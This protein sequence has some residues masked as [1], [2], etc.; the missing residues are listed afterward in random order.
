MLR[1]RFRSE[2]VKS[3]YVPI[4]LFLLIVAFL[5]MK[6]LQDGSKYVNPF[7]SGKLDE[8]AGKENKTSSVS[9]GKIND[10]AVDYNSSSQSNQTNTSSTVG[11]NENNTETSK[12]TV[13]LTEAYN[14]LLARIDPLREELNAKKKNI[15]A[16]IEDLEAAISLNKTIDGDFLKSKLRENNLTP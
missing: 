14:D 16:F 7:E 13:N 6:L 4:T 3:K 2:E 5:I 1:E 12:L 10:I 11:I 9:E 15:N 8:P